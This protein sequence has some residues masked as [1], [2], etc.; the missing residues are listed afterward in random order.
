MNHF[1]YNY[2]PCKNSAHLKLKFNCTAPIQSP[3]QEL[4]YAKG[5]AVK[6]KTDFIPMYFILLKQLQ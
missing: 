1:K 4:P 5:A 3:T 2:V 6:R